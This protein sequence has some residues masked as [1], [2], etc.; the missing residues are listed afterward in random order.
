MCPVSVFVWKQIAASVILT[1]GSNAQII[2]LA[3]CYCIT[4]VYHITVWPPVGVIITDNRKTPFI[5]IA[6]KFIGML[7]RIGDVAYID[8]ICNKT[9]Q[10]RTSGVGINHIAHP[11]TYRVVIIKGKP[12]R[13]KP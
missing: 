9:I 10:N 8:F 4:S 3:A 6:I 2:I 13:Q 1:A 11:E 5:I 7:C 12:R